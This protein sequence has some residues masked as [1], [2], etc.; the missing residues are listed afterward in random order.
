[1]LGKVDAAEAYECGPDK[2]TGGVPSAPEY[3]SRKDSQAESVG[4]MG[5]EEAIEAS[6]TLRKVQQT[7]QQRVMAGTRTGYPV[8]DNIGNLLG[9]AKTQRHRQ[10]S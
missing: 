6:P 9:E 3:Q 1:M 2:H 10:H 8:L 5:G 7:L 4:G